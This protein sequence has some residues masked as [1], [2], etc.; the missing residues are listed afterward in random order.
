MNDL[1]YQNDFKI[2]HKIF[3]LHWYLNCKKSLVKLLSKH[4]SSSSIQF[5]KLTSIINIKAISILYLKKNFARY[6]KSLKQLSCKAGKSCW[7]TT[8]VPQPISETK[9]NVPYLFGNFDNDPLV[10]V[11]VAFFSFCFDLFFEIYC[12]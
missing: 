7:F 12:F 5:S 1:D 10:Y 8:Q 11:K 2:E 6:K 4:M 3:R 9:Q